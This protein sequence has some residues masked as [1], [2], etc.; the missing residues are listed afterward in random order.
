MCMLESSI[1][2]C[3]LKSLNLV[4]AL[5]FSSYR[6]LNL[7]TYLIYVEMVD[8]VGT[9]RPKL[10]IHSEVEFTNVHIITSILD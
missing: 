3:T 4:I 2:K 5:F 8:L 7:M 10:G 9:S 1:G 6:S